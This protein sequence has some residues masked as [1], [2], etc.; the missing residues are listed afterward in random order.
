M[1]AEKKELN[2]ICN[3]HNDSE[4]D[5]DDGDDAWGGALN[6]ISEA[7]LNFDLSQRTARARHPI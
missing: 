4:D 7:K 1:S 6:A 5:D 3:K 2:Q